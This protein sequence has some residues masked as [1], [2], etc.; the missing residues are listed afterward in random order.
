MTVASLHGRRAMVALLA[1]SL[2]VPG[3]AFAE[4]RIDETTLAEGQNPVGGGMATYGPGSLSME[5][6]TA[7]TVATDENLAVT[8]DGGN[9]VD[10]FQVTA[11]ANVTV[12]FTGENTVEDIE[13]YD[14][15]N[16]TVNLNGHDTCEDL[17]AHDQSSLTVNV[18]GENGVE[19]VKGYDEAAVTVQGTTCPQKDV[20]EVGEDESS[21]RVGTEKGDL[22]VKDVTLVMQSTEASVGSTEGNTTIAC[23]KIE[24]G[25][26]N[27]RTD[28]V[29][30]QKLFVGG[31]V[32]DVT[33][34]MHSNDQM[35]IRRSDVDVRAP[36]G[37]ESPVRV[38]SQTGIE[39]IE[40]KNGSVVEDEL[41]GKKVWRVDTGDG[42][43]VHLMSALRPCYYR[44]SDDDSDTGAGHVLAKKLPIT[45]D[46]ERAPFLIAQI[47]GA[48]TLLAAIGLRRRTRANR[49]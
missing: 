5:G 3:T 31:S 6:V 17:E 13:S 18:T 44:C 34:T 29:A 9:D 36:E 40:E 21:E 1:L 7:G 22:V 16:V 25:D 45:A 39:L 48:G 10:K 11:D 37:D 8:F 42:K 2:S 19:S 35:T 14:T 15:S 27:K 43:D 32:I 20:L 46:S 38:W 41:D 33:G 30:G 12:N 24:S 4:V 23:S 26:D 28:I 49:D 47:M